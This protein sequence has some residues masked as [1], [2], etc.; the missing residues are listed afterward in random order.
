VTQN[1]LLLSVELYST[2]HFCKDAAFD[3]I[4][5]YNLLITQQLITMT[6]NVV[7][8]PSTVA[9]SDG[10]STD[11][12][13]SPCFFNLAYGVLGYEADTHSEALDLPN[14]AEGGCRF[15]HR[16]QKRREP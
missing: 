9:E 11:G 15:A 2:V 10:A 4:S 1:R 5:A 13:E 6:L 14:A 16:A 12:Y 8:P 7:C 3:Y